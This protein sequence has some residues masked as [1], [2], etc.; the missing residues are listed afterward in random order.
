MV[1]NQEWRALLYAYVQLQNKTDLSYNANALRSVT[2]DEPH[3]EQRKRQ[4]NAIQAWHVKRQVKPVRQQ[5]R[6]KILKSEI[7]GREV[8][9]DLQLAKESVLQHKQSPQQIREERIERERL[10]LSKK[11]EAWIISRIERMNEEQHQYAYYSEPHQHVTDHFYPTRSVPYLNYNLLHRVSESREPIPYNRKAVQAYA[12][13]YW[14]EPNSDY[15]HFEVDCTNFVSQCIFAGDVPMNYTGARGSGWWY[16]GRQKQNE[17]W[18][19]SWSVAHSM[20]LYLVSG[21][22]GMNAYQVDN[23]EELDIGDVIFYDWDGDSRF[24]HSTIVTA[25]D[26]MGMPLVNAH[27]NNSK[28]RYWDYRDSYAWT[29]RTKYR[30]IHLPDEVW[31]S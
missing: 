1:L 25:K 31:H 3:I 2:L 15:I 14:N 19:Y 30:F 28:H 12:N 9:L 18:T 4:I 16:K 8:L 7:H 10:T 26:P 6:A 23:P 5:T 17:W 29:E 20:Q 22:N 13:Q 11:N 24:Q 27:T 21:K